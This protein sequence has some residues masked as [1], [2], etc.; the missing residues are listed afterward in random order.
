MII[1]IFLV[2]VCTCTFSL[3]LFVF[4]TTIDALRHQEVSWSGQHY[5]KRLHI[6]LSAIPSHSDSFSFGDAAL[7]DQTFEQLFGEN[8]SSQQTTTTIHSEDGSKVNNPMDTTG[9]P[10]CL[11]LWLT[12]RAAELGFT[13]PTVIQ[14]RALEAILE[15]NDVIIHA[16]TGSGKTL[17]YLLPLFSLVDSSRA[18]VQGLIVVPTRELGL[19]VGRVA[20][21]LAAGSGEDGKK[22]NNKV[23][24]MQVL[25]G[26]QN[27]RQRAWAWADPPHIVI[28]TPEELTKMVRHGGIR[29]NAVKYVVVDEVD[30]CLLKS[31]DSSS[32]SPLHILLSRYLS[33]TF[34]NEDDA[35]LQEESSAAYSMV[36]TTASASEARTRV[37]SHG[38]DRQTVFVSATIP[39]HNH[40]RKQCVQNQWVVREPLHI[41][42]S[43]GELIPP[44]L[45]HSYVVCE[46]MSTKLGGLRRVLRKEI[47]QGKVKRVLIFCDS[48]RPME[49]IA[50]ALAKDLNGIVCREGWEGSYDDDVKNSATTLVSVLRYDESLSARASAMDVFQGA[51]VGDETDEPSDNNESPSVELKRR[52]KIRIMLSNDLAARGLDVS[53]V[54]H[55]VNFDIPNDGDIYI[56]RGGRAG[57]L[58]RSGSVITLIVPAQEF[59]LKRL[60]NMLNLNIKCAARQKP[61]IESPTAS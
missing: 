13:N 60:A 6:L 9:N 17:A 24:I 21:R 50:M 35:V 49:E 25:Q 33:P 14:Q 53:E 41:R 59:V 32:S 2:V 51:V 26:S 55:V 18:A 27:K 19:Q 43:P 5:G 12:N 57:R 11:P 22:N 40:F 3:L 46:S 44:G 34:A 29:Y 58:G 10:Y 45:R 38:K 30:A 8:K 56:H 1:R 42:A 48:D 61:L 28:G 20:K 39:Q 52:G 4:S 36:S 47:S 54:S 16:Q 23:M 37:I 7:V 31:N 15:R